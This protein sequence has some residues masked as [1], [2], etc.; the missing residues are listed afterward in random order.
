MNG[1]LW[2]TTKLLPDQ[3]QL[4]NPFLILALIPCFEYGLYPLCQ[5]FG[6]LKTPLQKIVTG[7]TLAGVAFI[8]TGLLELG[9]RVIYFDIISYNWYLNLASILAILPCRTWI[10]TNARVCV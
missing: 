3:I 4:A 7:G 1:E 10:R 6:M 9:L 8:I 5:K 2:G